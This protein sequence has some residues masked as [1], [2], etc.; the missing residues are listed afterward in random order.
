MMSDD[1]DPEL[2]VSKTL[3]MAEFKSG[4]C[5]LMQSMCGFGPP[6][7]EPCVVLCKNPPD[8]SRCTH[9]MPETCL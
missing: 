7:C 9:S 5:F 1:D 6:A 8:L 4:F 2:I 3:S